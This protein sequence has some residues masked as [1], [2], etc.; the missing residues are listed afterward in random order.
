MKPS[1]VSLGKTRRASY[2]WKGMNNNHDKCKP[3]DLFPSHLYKPA[4]LVTTWSGEKTQ[5]LL[6]FMTKEKEGNQKNAE[7]I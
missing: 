5:Q 6:D 2:M 7:S 3:I 1:N 4:D